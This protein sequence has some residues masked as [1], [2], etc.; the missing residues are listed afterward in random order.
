[1]TASR[2]KQRYWAYSMDCAGTEAHISSCS[3]GNRISTARGKN[4][5]C[6]NGMPVVVSCAPGRAF[7]PS[8]HSGYR[9]AFR[10]EVRVTDTGRGV[11]LQ[12]L[13]TLLEL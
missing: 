10:Q 2:R 6:E 1:M 8:S 3:L 13:P 7:A 12:V 9:K 4:I 11:D 5:T